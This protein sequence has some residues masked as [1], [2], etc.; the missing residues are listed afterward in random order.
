MHSLAANADDDAHSIEVA[1]ERGVIVRIEADGS[2]TMIPIRCSA[3]T[4]ALILIDAAD[5]LMSINE[6]TA[7]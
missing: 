7:H 3:E 1:M 6:M 2:Q 4:A 5:E